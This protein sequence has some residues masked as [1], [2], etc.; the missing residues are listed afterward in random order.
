MTVP[1]PRISETYAVN[2]VVTLATQVLAGVYQCL[3]YI[4]VAYRQK[5]LVPNE[6]LMKAHGAKCAT[7]ETDRYFWAY[8]VPCSIIHFVLT[9]ASQAY[10]SPRASSHWNPAPLADLCWVVP[11]KEVGEHQGVHHSLG[12]RCR[13]V[14]GQLHCRSQFCDYG[15]ISR[16]N[17]TL[18]VRILG[19]EATGGF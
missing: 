5:G 1:L 2:E 7:G 9:L 16:S 17:G 18:R 3:Y 13:G 11:G 14:V 6:T 15:V 4:F 12:Q 8:F 19:S 10:P